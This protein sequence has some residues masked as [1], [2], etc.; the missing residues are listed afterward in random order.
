MMLTKKRIRKTSKAIKTS[1]WVFYVGSSWLLRLIMIM[2]FRINSFSFVV[3][4]IYITHARAHSAKLCLFVSHTICTHPLF[5]DSWNS[6][7]HNDPYTEPQN[8]NKKLHTFRAASC[9]MFFGICQILLMN[10]LHEKVKSST[11]RVNMRTHTYFQ[12]NSTNQTKKGN[13]WRK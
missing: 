3:E 13:P 7:G 6:S 1:F 5:W 9:W 12:R 4:R 10:Q 8:N 11:A 2:K